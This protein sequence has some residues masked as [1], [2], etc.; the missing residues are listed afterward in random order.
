[1]TW[2]GVWLLL[3]ASSYWTQGKVQMWGGLLLCSVLFLAWDL[4]LSD[5]WEDW[6]LTRRQ[7]A[8]QQGRKFTAQENLDDMVTYM[9]KGLTGQLPVQQQPREKSPLPEAQQQLLQAEAQSGPQ[10]GPAVIASSQQVPEVMQ[11]PGV[12]PSSSTD[13]QHQPQQQQE[14]YGNGVGSS[15]SSQLGEVVGSR[16]IEVLEEQRQPSSKT[17]P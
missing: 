10:L 7:A 2:C 17:S 8:R 12:Q 3:Q 11:Q 16:Q 5:L 13:G 15:S 1:M 4:K 6:C 9:M 14:V